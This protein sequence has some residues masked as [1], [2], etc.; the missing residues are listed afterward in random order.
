MLLCECITPR[1]GFMS[2]P[3]STGEEDNL[4]P[5]WTLAAS[6][7]PCFAILKKKFSMTVCAA[8]LALFGHMNLTPSLSHNRFVLS[9]PAK[10]WCRSGTTFP[11]RSPLLY[12]PKQDELVPNLAP[13]RNWPWNRLGGKG[14]SQF[15]T[16]HDERSQLPNSY[17]S[18]VEHG[19]YIQLT[20]V[21]AKSTLSVSD[22]HFI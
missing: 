14:A 22:T 4:S 13:A 21:F 17:F 2:P 16:Q 1:A 8:L 12:L 11:G 20:F 18:P 3:T 10:K 6:L 7:P 19:Y 5:R 15:I 9:G